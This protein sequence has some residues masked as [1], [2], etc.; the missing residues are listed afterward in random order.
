MAFVLSLSLRGGISSPVPLSVFSWLW[1]GLVFWTV[2]CVSECGLSGAVL[3][4]SVLSCPMGVRHLQSADA[5]LSH[6]GRNLSDLLQWGVPV[7][8]P[9]A[10]EGNDD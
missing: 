5:K 6:P 7:A 3:G 4:S 2:G 10:H 8:N 1:R 9:P